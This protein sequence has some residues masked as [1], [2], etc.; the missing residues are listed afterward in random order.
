MALK[1][2]HFQRIF[3]VASKEIMKWVEIY[4]RFFLGN[5]HKVNT[6]AQVTLDNSTKNAINETF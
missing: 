6:V 3:S 5:F 4:H 2:T 1:N